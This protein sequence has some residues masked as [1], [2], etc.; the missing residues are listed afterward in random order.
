MMPLLF[1]YQIRVFSASFLLF[2]T[3]S[4]TVP[5]TAQESLDDI[6]ARGYVSNWLVCGPFAPDVAGGVIQAAHLRQATLGDTDP[7]A[8]LGGMAQL[9]P[10]HLLAVPTAG[11][12]AIWQNAGAQ[13]PSLDLSPFFPDANEGMAFAAFYVQAQA[14]QQA[15]FNLHTPFGA[16]IWHNGQPIRRM[17]P[18]PVESIGV[19]P[20]IA[21]FREGLNL[22]VIQVSG[23][24]FSALADVFGVAP[25]T[26]QTRYFSERTLLQGMSGFEIALEL[27]P[28]VQAGTVFMVPRLEDIGSFSGPPSDRRQDHQARLFN[29]SRAPSENISLT[30][31]TPAAI[32]ASIIN[33]G[34]LMPATLTP[35]TVPVPV[36]KTAA[37]ENLRVTVIL[38]NDGDSAAFDT[39]IEVAGGDEPGSIF[40]VT[41]FETAEALNPAQSIETV[42]A[43]SNAIAQL[44]AHELDRNYGFELG[45][46][47]DW[48][49]VLRARPSLWP[50]I[51][52][53]VNQGAVASRPLYADPDHRIVSGELLARALELGHEEGRHWLGDVAKADWSLRRPAVA[54]Q[55]PQLLQNFAIN[56]MATALET[57]MLPALGVWTGLDGTQVFHRLKRPSPPL[58][59]QDTFRNA[60]TAQRAPILSMGLSSDLFLHRAAD[61]RPDAVLT[62]AEALAA[63]TPRLPMR[64]DGAAEYFRSLASEPDTRLAA[65]AQ[66]GLQL[67]REGLGSVAAHPDLKRAYHIAERQ[68]KNA[69]TM[70]TLAALHG[71][72][73]PAATIEDGWRQLLYWTTPER[74]ALPGTTGLYA[75]ALSAFREVATSSH[76]VAAAAGAYLA[77]QVNT[78]GGGPPSTD[79]G[80]AVVVFNPSSVDFSG[81][82]A[83]EASLPS[84]RGMALYDAGGAPVPFETSGLRRGGDRIDR[85]TVHFVASEVPAFGHSTYYV[86]PAEGFPQIQ[87]FDDLQIENAHLY[88]FAD[89]VSGDILRITDKRTG[90]DYS[91]GAINRFASLDEAPQHTANGRHFATTGARSAASRLAAPVMERT[92]I[93]E[94][95]RFEHSL[96]GGTLEREISLYRD[97]NRVDF[98]TRLK[99]PN[100]DNKLVVATFQL[101]SLGRAPVLGERFGAIQGARGATTLDYR[102][103]DRAAPQSFLYPAHQWAALSPGERIQVGLDQD[104]PLRPAYVIHGADSLL[105]DAAQALVRALNERGLPAASAPAQWELPQNLWRDDTYPP[106]GW[107]DAPQEPWMR[108]LVGSPEQNPMTAA[109]LGRVPQDRIAEIAARGALGT[110]V[111]FDDIIDSATPPI[112]TLALF[113]LSPEKSA[114]FARA[115]AESIASRGVLAMP[116]AMMLSDSAEPASL[117]ATALLFPGSIVTAV[118]ED[119]ALNLLLA[120]GAS[121][122]GNEKAAQPD[123]L[124]FEYALAPMEEDWRLGRATHIAENFTARPVLATVPLQAG[125]L[126]PR[127]RY[128]DLGRNGSTL[129]ASLRTAPGDSGA[130]RTPQREGMDLRIWE[131]YGRDTALELATSF[132]LRRA[133]WRARAN[134][135]SQALSLGARGVA[136][137][138]AAK[139]VR[140]LQVFSDARARLGDAVPLASEHYAYGKVPNNYWRMHFGA[141]PKGLPDLAL[142]LDGTLEGQDANVAVHTAHFGSENIQQGVVVFNA[143]SGWTLQPERIEYILRPGDIQTDMVRVL[144][145]TDAAPAGALIAETQAGMTGLRDVLEWGTTP[146]RVETIRTHSQLKVTLRND[147]P[148]PVEGIL[149]L[150]V[151]TAYWGALAQ[152]NSPSAE[153]RRVAVA[154]G[155]H[156]FQTVL[157]RLPDPDAPVP[158]TLRLAVNNQVSY[159]AIPEETTLE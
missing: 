74:L 130:P 110:A 85:I 156:A 145:P 59:S 49:P 66:S 92:P 107:N 78:L 135:S 115:T 103:Y 105:G 104:I 58:H 142:S 128:L 139:Q 73:Y 43:V 4:L 127:H 70:A 94:T 42:K 22:I 33:P 87:R 148:S 133:Q 38:G 136:L 76:D 158:G 1:R 131:P 46:V 126:P 140:T 108:I 83:I 17:T 36:G 81:P 102:S 113:G 21:T 157:F 50:R 19:D 146:V 96:A 119:G 153:P 132:P 32:D 16:R 101:P 37:G 93:R 121:I 100:L 25:R 13:S 29:A 109:A 116:P 91:A 75:D 98:S 2:L 90:E 124:L 55:W 41:G 62:S 9:R 134:E 39:T 141:P 61:Y 65:L 47:S 138:L 57:P 88:V 35:V 150:V 112:P 30:V 95:L 27:A 7:M 79:G 106:R 154:I 24:D 6:L 80:Q 114:E 71:A 26:F 8:P 117:S 31:Q 137:E 129:V 23:A 125:P 18:G 99:T 60:L 155:A 68:L 149:D 11:A 48:L 77:S 151:P 152:P 84:P 143:P 97:L 28:V 72:E 3:T 118:D 63:A 123:Q 44:D 14:G 69:E 34:R 67:N 54:P 122:E 64:G 20:F 144:R 89:G 40:V 147:G 52:D 15:L 12:Q 159:H 56:G 53:A 45:Q 82:A 51:R 120:H 5:A 111:Y 86:V 10:R